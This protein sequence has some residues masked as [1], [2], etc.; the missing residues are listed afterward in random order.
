MTHT[1]HDIVICGG[2]LAGMTLA[3]QLRLEIPDLDV[4]VLDS[5]RYPVPVSAHKV[6]ESTVE[7]AGFYFAN[8]LGLESY[9]RARH[10]P[11]LGLRYFWSEPNTE[12]AA[13]L[14]LGLSNFTPRPSYQI[15]RGLLENDLHVMNVE[16]GVDWREGVSV[17]AIELQATPSSHRI[18]YRD[19]GGESQEIHARWVVDAM[20]R[21]RMLQR[22]L[23]LTKATPG[24]FSATWFRVL[25]R[26]DLAQF[27]PV[28][29][30][31]WHGRVVGGPRY[32]STNHLMGPGYWIWLIPLGSG[33]TSVGIVFDESFHAFADLDSFDRSMAWIARH[34]P[35]LAEHLEGREI[36]DFMAAR[37][38]AYSTTQVFSSARWAC[39]GEAA[40]FPDPFY[41]PGSNMIAFENTMLARMIADDR[42]GELHEDFVASCNE[43]V[44][45]QNDWLDYNIHSSYAYFGEPLVMSM[46]FLWDTVV[47][48][49]LA[50]AQL[51]NK[52]FL[53]R[54]ATRLTRA[55]I[56]RFY[57]LALQVKQLFIDWGR[58]TR[59]SLGFEFIDYYAVPFVKELSDRCLVKGKSLAELVDDHRYVMQRLEEFAQVIFL[60]AV[61]DVH[62]DQLARVAKF[63]W[64]DAWAIS[65]DPERW[66]P[67][68]LF[69]PTS[70]ARPLEPLRAQVRDLYRTVESP[71]IAATLD[72]DLEI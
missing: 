69:R 45:A 35:V 46:S 61:E 60:I 52:I 11:K 53:D 19:G 15:D 56:D 59:R 2:G 25:G 28:G 31:S 33:N 40:A 18:C 41:S 21:R 36:L 23:G 32:L 7:I 24:C 22:Q 8:I 26:L 3:R 57:P 70:A 5:Q 17:D 20:G 49:G 1:E 68:G 4:V 6:G 51:F 13:R 39:I 50:T 38:Y 47:G 55:E 27:V 65:L 67:D 16:A 10:L 9:M 14:E 48:W 34:D 62:P 44:I 64:L 63:G 66:E 29:E 72:I 43:F 71:V 54:E 58:Q 37:N 30:A 12:F 42:R